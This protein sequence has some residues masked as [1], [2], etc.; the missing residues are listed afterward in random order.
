MRLHGMLFA[1]AGL[2]AAVNAADKPFST[3]HEHLGGADSSQ[4][5]SLRQ[6]D[7]SNVKQLRIAWTYPTGEGNY[8]FN[9]IVIDGV[10]YVQAKNNSLVA[11]DAL[12][13]KEFWTH[14]FQGPVVQR[15]INYWEGPGK[16]KKPPPIAAC[17]PSMPV[18]SPPSTRAPARP[19]R[20]LAITAASTF[21]PGSISTGAPSLP[22]TPT[23][24]DASSTTS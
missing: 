21:G 12:T 18:S 10:M 8:L 6:I 11:L 24:P 16:G 4:Y 1:I 20:A 19:F 17:S 15:G 7:K 9:P 3:W 13:G 14:P 2:A 23:T 5:S 22:S